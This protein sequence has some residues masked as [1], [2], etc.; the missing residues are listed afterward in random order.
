[1][2]KEQNLKL[3]SII[4]NVNTEEAIKKVRRINNLVNELEAEINSLSKL[5]IELKT[6]A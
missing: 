4:F 6:K 3:D 2:K 5:Q 1:M